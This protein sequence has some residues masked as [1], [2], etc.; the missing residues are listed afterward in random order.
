L[1]PL[2]RS[3]RAAAFFLTLLLSLPALAADWVSVPG[4]GR[5]YDRSKVTVGHVAPGSRDIDGNPMADFVAI[6]FRDGS[7]MSLYC[8]TGQ[9]RM[10]DAPAQTYWGG[11]FSD[12]PLAQTLAGEYCPRINELPCRPTF[13]DGDPPCDNK[14]F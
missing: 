7:S 3:G 12:M 14:N 13:M 2:S 9:Y 4:T 10:W 6:V 5:E 11:A 1:S 8:A